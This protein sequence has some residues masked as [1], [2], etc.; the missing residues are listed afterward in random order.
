MGLGLINFKNASASLEITK[1]CNY[2]C[3]FCYCL[4]HEK[5]YPKIR[6]ISAAAWLKILEKLKELGVAKIT[7]TGGE[8]LLKKGWEEI[9]KRAV[10]LFGGE[11]CSIYTNSKLLNKNLLRK[12]KKL[13]IGVCTSLQGLRAH[14]Q[15][16][17]VSGGFGHTLEMLECASEIGL[18]MDCA[19]VATKANLGEYIDILIAA[20]YAG[21]RRIVAGIFLRG[22]RGAENC[23]ELAPS[24]EEWE[25]LKKEIRRLKIAN[26][27]SDEEEC[28]CNLKI[29]SPGCEAGK[30]FF[31][32][33][34]SGNVRKCLH[35]S[36]IFGN[37]LKL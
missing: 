37:L 13:G 10:A 17:G 23:K 11:N 21:A 18:G 20:K 12:F 33:D 30:R 34:P 31:A 24:R 29:E 35:S 16:A 22:G 26:I 3:P 19:C 4:W 9:L 28:N 7:L 5:S 27:F 32:V 1:R 6:E 25:S 36:L 14:R 15:M 2:R 8:P